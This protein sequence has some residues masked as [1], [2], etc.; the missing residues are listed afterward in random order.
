MINIGEVAKLLQRSVSTAR[1]LLDRLAENERYEVE[2][3]TDT[4]PRR[5]SRRGLQRYADERNRPIDWSLI[6]Q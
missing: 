2:R 6:S 4:S 3:L 1:R 5:I